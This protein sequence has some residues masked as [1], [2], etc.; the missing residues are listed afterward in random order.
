M[1]DNR[2]LTGKI[3]HMRGK[4]QADESLI[5]AFCRVRAFEPDFLRSAGLADL[6]PSE[7]IP[8]L[9]EAAMMVADAIKQRKKLLLFGDFD[10]DGMSGTAL[11]T[12]ALRTLGANVTAKLPGRQDGYGLS[13]KVFDEAKAAGIDLIITIDCGSANGKQI[14]Y[15]KSLGID[16][17]V[18]DHHSIPSQ[19]PRPLV[20]VHPH[21]APKTSDFYE[22]TGAGVA[23]YLARA[24]LETSH[25]DSDLSG[26]MS[27]LAELAILGTVADVGKLVGQNRVLLQI[28]LAS[29]RKTKHPGILALLNAARIEPGEITAETIAFYLAP[30][31]NAAGRVAHPEWS[32]QL[33]LGDPRHAEVICNQL[34]T[35]HVIRREQ[36]DAL[37]EIAEN[38]IDAT[39]TTEALCHV[40][41]HEQF[42]AGIAG[43][44]AARIAEKYSVPAIVLSLGNEPDILTASC[45]GPE[46]FHFAEAL[47]QLSHLLNKFG[48]HRCAAGF[49]MPAKNLA[50]FE[51]EFADLVRSE[52]GDKPPFSALTAD[53][54]TEVAELVV[55]DFETLFRAAP[56]GTGNPEP[57]FCLRDIGFPEI[58]NIG[59][60]QV[61]LAGNLGD[62]NATLP[63]IAFRFAEHLPENQQ[64]KRFDALVHPEIRT[65]RGKK[66]LQLKIA[67]LRETK[68][69]L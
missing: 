26:I 18:T 59:K 22:I 46:D 14:E 35:F 30:R 25:P 21:L 44:V 36:T 7:Q 1:D 9:V 17:I 8:N 54:D 13:P 27:K 33:L 32:L 20:F 3:W 12:L 51:A 40:L 55:T 65:F 67:D 15:G 64:N 41:H 5:E 58:R 34:E 52:R 50:R 56:F 28:G 38:L 29:I 37:L 23:F 69:I 24:L 31:L 43:L 16:T 10:L 68:E 66:T 53:F 39:K 2:S 49:S 61:H 47:K 6:T 57:L 48:G 60:D 63:F 42:S 19:P 4:K 62:Q 11:L 45:R